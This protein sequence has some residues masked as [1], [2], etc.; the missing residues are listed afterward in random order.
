M[1][2]GILTNLKIQK[3]THKFEKIN[4]IMEKYIINDYSPNYDYMIDGD[5]IYSSVK[6]K[7]EWKDISHIEK[8]RNN[9]Y[10][11]VRSKQKAPYILDKTFTFKEIPTKNKIHIIDNYSPNYNY[12]VEGDKMY[13]SKKGQDH[14]IDISD[15]DKA[16]ANLYNFL[17]TKYNFKG[18]E[19]DEK[20]I[21]NQIK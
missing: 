19:D 17:G 20:E 10:S 18:Y 7:N 6:G 1:G 4:N 9:L 11:F 3:K 5:K 15:N 2:G 21:W 8:A 14:W 16:R 13:S 12:I